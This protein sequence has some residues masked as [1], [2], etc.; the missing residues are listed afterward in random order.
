MSSELLVISQDGCPLPGDIESYRVKLLSVYD[1][2]E[3]HQ[4]S[5][6][7]LILGYVGLDS[8]L[9]WIPVVGEL[10]SGAMTF[11]LIG[12]AG[13]VKMPLGGRLMIILFGI[14][15]VV[16][17]MFTGAGDVVDFFFR[18][19]A[20]NAGRVK[21]HIAMQVNQIEIARKQISTMGPIN[22]DH[23][24]LNHLRDALFRG[25]KSK[26]GVW[27]QYG[28]I[29]LLCAGLFSYCTY[30]ENLRQER[31]KACHARN[32]WFCEWRS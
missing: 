24:I 21:V 8:L 27:I 20:W 22:D 29:A 28:L 23:P 17:G 2:M 30:Q 31:I 14:L 25:G 12:K 16:I 6:D 4:K 11:W 5:M 19:H 7:G 26:T 1:E 32:G 13:Q 10:L 15:D 3:K 18:A 9:G